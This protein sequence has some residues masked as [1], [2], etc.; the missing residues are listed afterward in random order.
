[1]GAAWRR[2]GTGGLRRGHRSHAPLVTQRDLD[3]VTDICGCS[4]RSNLAFWKIGSGD[5]L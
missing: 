1:M 2:Q 3:A 4:I 5:R